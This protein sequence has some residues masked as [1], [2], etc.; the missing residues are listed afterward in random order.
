[1]KKKLVIT[2]T[3]CLVTSNLVG[4]IKIMDSR[5]KTP[6]Y[7]NYVYDSLVNV[8]PQD[9][10]GKKSLNYLEGQTLLFCGS[11]DGY[12]NLYEDYIGDFKMGDYYKVEEVLPD[13]PSKGKYGRMILNNTKTGKKTFEGILYVD[14]LNYYWVVVGYY[15]KIRSLYLGKEYVYIKGWERELI[16]LNTDT[17]TNIDNLSIWKCVDAQVKPR[18]NSDNMDRSDKRCPIVLIFENPKYGKQYCFLE[19][20]WGDKNYTLSTKYRDGEKKL[21]CGRFQLKAD[22]DYAQVLKQEKKAELIKKYGTKNANDI[23]NGYIRI[24]MSKEMCREAWGNP[25][26]INRSV[27]SYG[28]SEQWVY[29]S[30][31][32]YFDGNRISAIQN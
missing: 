26:R 27:T 10:N 12:S 18:K 13:L 30:S 11:S 21:L 16:D 24:G 3:L 32:V 22:Y 20:M 14:K 29:G 28:S 23:T 15:N 1:M 17:L 8:R 31:Y 5:P 7:N 4:Q 19:D 25:D 9:Y 2:I 6:Q